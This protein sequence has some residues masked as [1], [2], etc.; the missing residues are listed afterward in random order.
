[1]IGLVKREH[2]Y[3]INSLSEGMIYPVLHDPKIS[4]Y[5]GSSVKLSYGFNGK[6]N[7]EG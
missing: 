4:A 3:V 1:M 7:N 5:F 6:V 2:D